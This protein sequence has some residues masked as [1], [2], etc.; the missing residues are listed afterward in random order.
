MSTAPFITRSLEV[1]AVADEE[2]LAFTRPGWSEY[3]ARFEA[4]KLAAHKGI[5]VR[6][7]HNGEDTLVYI[8][9]LEEG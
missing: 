5:P 6:H 1:A 7:R 4:A 9:H 8:D 2:I 3:V